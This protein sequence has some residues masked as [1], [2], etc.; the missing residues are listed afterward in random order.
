[1]AQQIPMADAKLKALRNEKNQTVLRQKI[2]N[3]K[4]GTPEDLYV[5]IQYY[6]KKNVAEKNAVTQILLKKYPE[7][8][9]TRMVRAG[10]FINVKPGEGMEALLDTLMKEY[11]GIN[12]DLEK[13]VVASGYAEIQDLS[14]ADHFINTLTDPYFRG[15]GLM[16]MIKIIDETNTHAAL[17][18]ADRNL[19]KVKA[20]KGITARSGPRKVVPDEVYNEFINLYSKLLFKAG[21]NAAAYEYTK[22]AYSH[23][24]DRDVALTENYAFLSSSLEG[25]YEEALPILAK[26]IKEGKNDQRYIE[27]VRKGYAKLNPGKDVD[28]YIASLQNDFV[29]KIQREVSKLMVNETPPDFYV[30]DIHGKKVTLADFKGKTIVLDFWATWCGPCVASFP[31]MQMVVNR[32]KNDP[33]VKFLFIHTAEHVADPLTDAKNFLSQRKYDFDLYMD[34]TDPAIKAGPA[35]KAFKLDGIPM[36]YIIDANGKIRFKISGFDRKDEEA[37]EEVSQMIEMTRKDI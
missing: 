10:L 37:A 21:K 27:Q 36:K 2:K 3:L 4:K 26:A 25:K 20:F 16:E 17:D 34:I 1:M 9:L 23:A 32:Y 33:D 24:K 14:K 22:E 19:E 11:P 29:T 35:L 31:A 12:L 8:D 5:L 30:K 6:G 13:F 28:T 7:D 15:V 18:F